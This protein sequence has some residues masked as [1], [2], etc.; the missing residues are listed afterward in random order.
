[1][2]FLFGLGCDLRLACRGLAKQA[3]F[4]L[5]IVGIL[6]IGVVGM[7]TVFDLFNGLCLRPFPVP[8]ADRLME[9]HETDPKTGDRNVGSAYPRFRAW[10]QYNQTFE[11]TIIG[12][13]PPEADF[14]ERKEVWRPLRANAQGGHDSMDMF[15]IGLLKRG[16][17]VAHG[18]I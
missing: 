5:M 9:L 7:T 6:A 16:V 2:T 8:T 17:T 14:R 12:V 18:R 3:G 4:T 13:L 1:M 10:R 15:A 11:C